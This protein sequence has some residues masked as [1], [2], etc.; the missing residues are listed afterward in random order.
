MGYQKMLTLKI[1]PADL[2]EGIDAITGEHPFT[3]EKIAVADEKTYCRSLSS[4]IPEGAQNRLVVAQHPPVV[5]PIIKQ[6]AQDIKVSAVVS[7]HLQ[8]SE[9]KLLFFFILPFQVNIGDEIT[10]FLH[11]VQERINTRS[12]AQPAPYVR[13]TSRQ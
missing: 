12:Y 9:K 7:N 3:Q 10:F 6:I 4:Q 2:P 1:K 11:D 5:C 13:I 8:K